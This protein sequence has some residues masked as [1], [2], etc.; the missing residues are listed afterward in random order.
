M[1]PAAFQLGK[2]L[3]QYSQNK[4]QNKQLVVAIYLILIFMLGSVIK[5]VWPKAE[6]YNYMQEAV[7]WVE[8]NNTNHEPVFYNESRMRYYAGEKFIGTW[9]SNFEFLKKEIEDESIKNFQWVLIKS[10][11]SHPDHQLIEKRLP[12]YKLVKLVESNQKK[13]VY[14]YKL[15]R[16]KEN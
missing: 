11:N 7:A 3:T 8:A 1:I 14:I 13:F 10:S 9:N 5:N 15:D 16:S 2:L 12:N 6:G 4:I